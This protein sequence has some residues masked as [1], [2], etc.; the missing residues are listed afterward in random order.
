VKPS[1]D[2]QGAGSLERDTPVSADLRDP[3]RRKT[4]AEV[5]VTVKIMPASPD[6]DLDALTSRIGE[7]AG[8]RL[9]NVEREPIAFGLVALNASYVVEDKEG[10]TDN[11]ESAIKEVDEVNSAEVVE[12][13]RLL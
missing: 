10:G 8:G 13:T 9:N 1:A 7:V 11:L 2:V 4:M 6:V 3:K 12:V 5:L